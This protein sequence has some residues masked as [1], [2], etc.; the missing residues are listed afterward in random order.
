MSNGKGFTH[1]VKL[2]LIGDTGK[3]SE[4]MLVFEVLRRQFFSLVTH[5]FSLSLLAPLILLLAKKKT[6]ARGQHS[7]GE[8]QRALAVF[9]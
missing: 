9:R 2:L 3:Q 6:R 8:E 1:L 5:L 4:F 7:G